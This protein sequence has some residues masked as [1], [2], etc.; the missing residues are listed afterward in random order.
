[1]GFI[2]YDIR[3]GDG[4]KLAVEPFDTVCRAVSA[5]E[6]ADDVALLKRCVDLGKA[7]N[8]LTGL[9]CQRQCFEHALL[10]Q[11]VNAR[12]QVG[13]RGDG[14]LQAFSKDVAADGLFD[15]GPVEGDPDA[16]T[17]KPDSQI[18]HDHA[19]ETCTEADQVCDWVRCSR[20]STQ[21]V[22]AGEL[23][24]I[25]DLDPIRVWLVVPLCHC[26]VLY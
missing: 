1:M 25:G 18:R 2:G 13:W 23:G 21:P 5:V 22:R 4:T 6:Q 16:A 14:A 24:L 17:R 15:T 19:V 8:D 9:V 12:W 11:G 20:Q 7:R 26:D 10:Q 3:C